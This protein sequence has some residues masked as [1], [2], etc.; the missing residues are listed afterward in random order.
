M[1]WL[2]GA[3]GCTPFT[4]MSKSLPGYGVY[5]YLEIQSQLCGY[6]CSTKTRKR[7]IRIKVWIAF[8]ACRWVGQSVFLPCKRLLPVR[9][10]HNRKFQTLYGEVP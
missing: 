1:G 3:S 10:M 2:A 9:A 6:S 5:V 4:R 7:S 8:G